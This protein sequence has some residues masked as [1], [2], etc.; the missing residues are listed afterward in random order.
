MPHHS[1]LSWLI[2]G[3]FEAVFFNGVFAENHDDTGYVG[4]CR[5]VLND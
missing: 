4:S 5:P 3:L 2:R 1:D